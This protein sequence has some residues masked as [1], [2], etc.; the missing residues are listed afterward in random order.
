MTIVEE[1][2]KRADE[3][4]ERFLNLEGTKKFEA[5]NMAESI[6]F[7]DM[8]IASTIYNE[9]TVTDVLEVGDHFRKVTDKLLNI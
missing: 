6:I 8:A 9:V 7:K 3:L 1:N 4:I 5:I 2:I